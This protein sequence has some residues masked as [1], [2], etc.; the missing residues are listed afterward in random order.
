MHRAHVALAQAALQALRLDDLRWIPA[1]NPWQKTRTITAAAHR[2]AMV[3]LALAGEPRFVLDHTEVDRNGPSYML[4]TVR[5]LAAAAGRVRRFRR[6]RRRE[7][8]LRAAR[9]RCLRSI[10]SDTPQFLMLP[11][12][13][14]LKSRAAMRT[15]IEAFAVQ[16]DPRQ[17]VANGALNGG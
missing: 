8:S 16:G 4:D 11:D 15:R 5:A 9:L 10:V 14:D 2:V 3:Q 13:R 12:I 7:R 6:Q 17:S 1:G